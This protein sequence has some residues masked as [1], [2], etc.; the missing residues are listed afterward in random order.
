M[1]LNH[2]SQEGKT[3][4][5][6]SARP[7]VEKSKQDLVLFFLSVVVEQPVNTQA[8]TFYRT[9]PSPA[10]SSPGVSS[11]NLSA[12]TLGF[13]GYWDILLQR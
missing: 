6:V 3:K 1:Q 9:L 4:G 10:F 7:G 2:L 13:Y 5:G 12:E 11:D 8:G